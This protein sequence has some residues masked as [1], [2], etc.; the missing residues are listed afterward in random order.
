VTQFHHWTGSHYGRDHLARALVVLARAS[1]RPAA[2][3]ARIQRLL[4]PPRQREARCARLAAT[5]VLLLP[6]AI[7]CL[8]LLIAACDA[9]AHP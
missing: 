9:T 4:A 5:A 1:S 7:A 6:A 3:I 8:P 2:A